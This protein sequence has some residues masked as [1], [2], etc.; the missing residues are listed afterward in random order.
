MMSPNPTL[1][2]ARSS[3][4]SF[5]QMSSSTSGRLSYYR[6]AGTLN[7]RP[8]SCPLRRISWINHGGE[9]LCSLNRPIRLFSYFRNQKKKKKCER[10]ERLFFESGPPPACE[11]FMWRVSGLSL[12]PFCE[13]K[14]K[15]EEEPPGVY[16]R[17]MLLR[18]VEKRRKSERRGPAQSK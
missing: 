9:K 18:I 17:L 1:P 14:E 11:T 3:L 12:F 10:T 8:V 7:G 2:T 15:E 4:F 6:G 5:W 13:P 16:I